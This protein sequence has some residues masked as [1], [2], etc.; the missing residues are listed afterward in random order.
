VTVPGYRRDR[1]EDLGVY[2]TRSNDQNSVAICLTPGIAYRQGPY[3]QRERWL[4]DF[5][6]GREKRM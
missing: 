4:G 2:Y 5:Q 1:R 6:Q 3:A